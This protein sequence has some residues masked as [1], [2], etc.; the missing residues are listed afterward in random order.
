MPGVIVTQHTGT[1]KGNQFFLRGFNLDHGTDFLVEVGGAPINLRS[2]GH[3]QGYVDLN[4]LIPE[5]VSKVA[6]RK[7]PYY[8]DTGDFSSAGSVALDFVR[9]LPDVPSESPVVQQARSGV[10]TKASPDERRNRP[11]GY[12][13]RARAAGMQGTVEIEVTVGADGRVRRALVSGSSGHALLDD[14]ALKAVKRWRFAPARDASGRA[15]ADTLIVPI[16]FDLEDR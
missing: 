9:E 1:G 13:R 11:P 14:E 7:G 5:L 8:A 2:H 16:E 3:G 15:V 10:T 4:F 12:P 6:Y